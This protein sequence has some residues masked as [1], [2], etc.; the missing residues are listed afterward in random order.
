MEEPKLQGRRVSTL[1]NMMIYIYDITWASFAQEIQ[2]VE[3]WTTV[4]GVRRGSWHWGTLLL[5]GVGRILMG[6]V[7]VVVRKWLV[8]IGI[9][10]S[11][12]TWVH[13][14]L[15]LG[16][17]RLVIFVLGKLVEPLLL[18]LDE[19][20]VNLVERIWLLILARWRRSIRIMILLRWIVLSMAIVAG[21]FDIHSIAY[22]IAHSS[23]VWNTIYFTVIFVQLL[24]LDWIRTVFIDEL[25]TESYFFISNFE[26]VSW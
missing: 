19:S 3:V 2:R 20:L 22:S 5:I 6:R 11:S 25:K 17:S 13:S 4:V 14:S 10:V 21:G 26:M 18:L 16:V 12:I 8:G 24:E 15:V 23:G 7:L 1:V 9:G